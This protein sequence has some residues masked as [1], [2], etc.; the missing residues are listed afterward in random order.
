MCDGKLLEDILDLLFD[1]DVKVLDKMLVKFECD[2][3]KEWFVEVL[4]VLF[5][6][7]V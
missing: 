3:F 4:M 1:G 5:K 6:Y 7:E 2:C